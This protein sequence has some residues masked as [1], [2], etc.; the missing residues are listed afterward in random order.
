MYSNC[1]RVVGP[2]Q[3]VM[4]LR[5]LDSITSMALFILMKI[6]LGKK[7][8]FCKLYLTMEQIFTISLLEKRCNE[9]KIPLY[10][11]FIDYEKV[12]D[13]VE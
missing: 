1:V 10:I 3:G 7:R 13:S 11:L 8:G 2:V 4:M 5:V 6:L 9:C 12:F